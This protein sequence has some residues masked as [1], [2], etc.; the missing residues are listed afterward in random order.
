MNEISKLELAGKL[1]SQRL[2]SALYAV[3]AGERAT[4]TELRLRR[5]RYF[6]ASLYGREYFITADGR[7]MN[8]PE[9]AVEVTDEDIDLAFKNAFRGSVHSFPREIAQGYI[10]CEGG[11]RVGFCGTAVCAPQGGISSVKGISSVNIRIAREIKGCAAGIAERVFSDGAASLIIASPPCGG[12]TTMLRDLSRILSE[13]YSVSL[14][15]ERGELAAVSEGKPCCDVGERTDVFSGY[16]KA[17]AVETAVRVMSPDIIICDEIGSSD[18]LRSLEY[19]V[20]SGSKIVCS[21]HASTYD[22]LKKR[23]AA[24]KLIKQGIFDYAAL[25]GKGSMCG[26]LKAFYDL[27]G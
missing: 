10:T 19:A 14:I 23:P 25:L 22:E 12:K 9:D 15:D 11:N 24:G 4:M 18:D 6:S 16:P 7:L 17:E 2:K 5:G 21:C 13:S 27:K 1:L 8:R 20:N 3:T 26:R